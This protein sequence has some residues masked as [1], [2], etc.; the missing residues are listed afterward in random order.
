MYVNYGDISK[1]LLYLLTGLDYFHIHGWCSYYISI[2]FHY[3]HF[4]SALLTLMFTW[5]LGTCCY[6]RCDYAMCNTNCQNTNC[7]K[8]FHVSVKNLW[9][10]RLSIPDEIQKLFEQQLVLQVRHSRSW[11][12][13]VLVQF[14]LSGNDSKLKSSYDCAKN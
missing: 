1:V 10:G 6:E 7:T 5:L 3:M 11:L 9:L 12:V 2:A 4:M 8:G 13:L 14:H